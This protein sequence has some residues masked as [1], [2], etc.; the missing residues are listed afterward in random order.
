MKVPRIFVPENDSD[1][2]LEKFLEEHGPDELKNALIPKD[3]VITNVMLFDN[4]EIEP[5]AV[6]GYKLSFDESLERLRKAG[7]ERHLR[8]WEAFSLIIN[9]L[10]DNLQEN[11]KQTSI[12]LLCNN[13]GKVRE[14]LS[15]AVKREGDRLICYTDPENLLWDDDHYIILGGKL[16]YSSWGEFDITG[17]P[18][19]KWVDLNN[20]SND[21]IKFFYTREFGKLPWQKWQ[22][23]YNAEVCL[24]S[25]DGLVWP[26][27]NNIGYGR[28]KIGSYDGNPKNTSFNGDFGISRGV[29]M[30]R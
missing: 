12:E 22:G 29:R 21:F 13:N 20:F 16:K 15:T 9:S 24:P 14:W 18:S 27:T 28:F 11:L 8:T 2:K 4:L 1:R 23:H 5:N 10:E 19:L 7:Y 3:T 17:I 6:S 30:K 25:D 26:V